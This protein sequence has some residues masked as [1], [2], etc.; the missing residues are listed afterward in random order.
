MVIN[1]SGKKAHDS[2]DR[3]LQPEYCN[4]TFHHVYDI[5]KAVLVINFWVFFI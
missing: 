2:D 4:R 3:S 1:Q 5:V